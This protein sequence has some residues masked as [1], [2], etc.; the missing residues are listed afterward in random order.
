LSIFGGVDL[1]ILGQKD[2]SGRFF[3]ISC[4]F[5]LKGPLRKKIQEIKNNLPELSFC[6]EIS[7]STPPKMLKIREMVAEDDSK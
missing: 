1:E 5:F 4:I 6:P 3:L 7:G 2:S